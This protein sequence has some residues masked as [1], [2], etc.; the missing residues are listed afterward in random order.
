MNAWMARAACIGQDPELFYGRTLVE[1]EEAKSICES[2]PVKQQCADYSTDETWGIW[3]GIDRHAEYAAR[4]AANQERARQKAKALAEERR[5]RTRERARKTDRAR[6]QKVRDG[7]AAWRA[8]DRS[9]EAVKAHETWVRD[10]ERK[11]QAQR[12]AY[13][14]AKQ[15]E[16][17]A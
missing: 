6:R 1:I 14:R 5:I 13:W 11:R 8:G 3:G 10:A 2:C 4:L 7:E 15:K 16:G 17:A 9:K 12:R